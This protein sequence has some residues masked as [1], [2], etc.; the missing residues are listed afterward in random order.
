MIT[1]RQLNHPG[2]DNPL[3]RLAQ[4]HLLA[5]LP[6]DDELLSLTRLAHWTDKSATPG[7]RV[8]SYLEVHCAVCHQPGGASRGLFDARITTPLE[9]AG[10]ING[11]LAAGDLGIAGAKVVVPGAPEKSILFRRLSDTGFF[12]MPPVQYHNEPSPIL[13]IVE[14]WIRQMAVR[15]DLNRQKP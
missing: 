14:E 4:Q 10:I 8:R 7:L 6:G 5:G 9:S 1:A 2:A 12:R 13:P 15:A 11:E 3:R